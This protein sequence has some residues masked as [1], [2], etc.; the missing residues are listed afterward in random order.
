M[1]RLLGVVIGALLI[2]CPPWMIYGI[3]VP[4][5]KYRAGGPSDFLVFASALLAVYGGVLAGSL[6]YWAIK[7]RAGQTSTPFGIFMAGAFSSLILSVAFAAYRGIYG[8]ITSHS[9]EN[10]VG[11]LWGL[12]VILWLLFDTVVAAGIALLFFGLQGP[13]ARAGASQQAA[14]PSG[15]SE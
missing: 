9:F 5:P 14:G 1:R 13:A 2:G 6:V 10:G 12:I 4:V 3:T 11:N 8:L 7:K 15:V